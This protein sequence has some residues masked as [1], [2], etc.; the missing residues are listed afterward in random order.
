MFCMREAKSINFYITLNCVFNLLQVKIFKVV[1]SPALYLIRVV[2]L[3]MDWTGQCR[4]E[5]IRLR[6]M[7]VALVLT[8]N[9]MS[10]L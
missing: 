10:T 8:V 7:R 1:R 2:Y 6:L 9:Y 4:C 5:L 3:Y